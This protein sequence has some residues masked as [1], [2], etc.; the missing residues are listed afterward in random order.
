MAANAR[1]SHNLILSRSHPAFGA[2][3]ETV[4]FRAGETILAANRTT[5]HV[6][7]PESLVATFVRHLLDGSTIGAGIVGFEGVIGI[8][9]MFGATAQPSDV[10]VQVGG[11]AVRVPA[12]IAGSV[13][14]SDREFRGLVLRFA[15]AFA[16][17]IGQAAVCNWFHPLERRLSYWLLNVA[18]RIASTNGQK[19]I[20]ISL[21][22]E[23]LANM[24]GTRI[25][26]IN[27]A[28]S[29]LTTSG[30]IRH[31]RHLIEIVDR[32]GLEEGA[33]ECYAT[34][35]SLYARDRVL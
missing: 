9:A 24:L 17:Q 12:M 10:I 27:E 2:S 13:F 5:T 16:L 23:F 20:E 33:C 30:L 4:T 21:T 7:F 8:E 11:T 3:A 34:V 19:G 22:Q 35:S 1:N 29:T 6:F 31:R 26:S 14:E 18:D 15:N 25:A 28:I 32:P